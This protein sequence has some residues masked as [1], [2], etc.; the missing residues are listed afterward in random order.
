MTRKIKKIY[1]FEFQYTRR[2]NRLRLPLP[3]PILTECTNKIPPPLPLTKIH[4]KSISAEIPWHIWT[5]LMT[6][7]R[8]LG[9]RFYDNILF[10]FYRNKQKT[11]QEQLGKSLKTQSTDIDR[12]TELRTIERLIEL[13]KNF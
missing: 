4:S 13:F 5:N 8:V 11:Y 12:V 10:H 7:N 1:L 9:R 2:H 3:S 6:I